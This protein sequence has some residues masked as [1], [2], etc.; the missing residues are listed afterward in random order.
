MPTPPPIVSDA[1]ID[2]ALAEA[3]RQVDQIPSLEDEA[4]LPPGLV[5]VE[6]RAATLLNRASAPPTTQSP[7]AAT[8]ATPAAP[9]TDT[10]AAPP[11]IDSVA[12]TTVPNRTSLLDLILLA[13]DLL[14]HLLNWPLRRLAPEARNLVGV[15]AIITLVMA[16]GAS[17]LPLLWPPENAASALQRQADAQRA[18]QAQLELSSP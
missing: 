8:M 10:G 2:A 6:T 17:F 1:E 3:E 13:L 18:R 15:V 5:P 7:A 9:S 4:R 16:L 11:E 14:L 12:A